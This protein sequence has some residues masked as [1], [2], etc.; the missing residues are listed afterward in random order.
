MSQKM[1]LKAFWD[2]VEHRLADCS[3]DELRSIVRALA[4][5]VPPTGR[6]AFLDQLKPAAETEAI[7]QQVTRAEDLLA[8]IDELADEIR[9]EMEEAEYWEKDDW[10]EYGEYEEESGLGPYEQ[11]L[12]PLTA[13]FDRAE[14]VFDYGD[15]VLARQAYKKLFEIFTLEDD[16][17]RGI[18]ASDLTEVNMDQA[19]ARYLRA[20]YESEPPA[21]RPEILF[22]QMEQTRC[23]STRLRPTLEE[24]I[25][26]LPRPLPDQES[27]LTA[28]VAFL[29][30][31]SGAN[32]DAWL[33]EAIRL[34]Q[35]TAGLAELARTEGKQHPRTYLDWFTALEAEGQ[36]SVVLVEAQH[37]LQ[38]L[39][40]RLPIRAA[41]ADHLCAA[42][43]RL[44][45]PEV[46]RAGRWEAF[47][48]KPTLERLLDL[49]EAASA[50][51]EQTALMRQAA[52]HVQNHIAHPPYSREMI[53]P[54]WPGDNVETPVRGSPSVMAHAY[55]L[56]GEW[57]TARQLAAKERVLGWSSSDSIQGLVMPFFLVFLSG[58][59]PDALPP[60]LSGLWQ[61]R[62]QTSIG[63]NYWEMQDQSPVLQRLER[64]YT[65]LLSRASLSQTQQEHLVTWCLKIANQRTDAIVG[66]QHRGSYGKAAV[67][68]AAC[69]EM[70]RLRG[71]DR[72]ASDL[73]EDVRNRFPRHRAFQAAMDMAVGRTGRKSTQS[74]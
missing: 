15:L 23:W 1:S 37:A 71:K 60:S 72:E 74:R 49:W 41:I 73:I 16:Y 14:A 67:L 53:D 42:A 44:E 8:D 64:A 3:A 24:I 22:K 51:Q 47:S 25:Q 66:D 46:L 69:A 2:E 20:V 61:Q 56:A 13:L 40:A 28:W 27:F 35:G 34:S 33:R 65:A 62:L 45:Q 29:R 4:Q 10:Y 38:T 32:A 12:E 68:I 63:Y 6:Q 55:L 11:F 7:P 18:S 70:L 21:R 52:Q 54:N 57:E 19:L 36:H 58:P 5:Q 50:D 39:D 26:I 48:V 31:Q 30:K 59:K 9:D 17:G 43:I